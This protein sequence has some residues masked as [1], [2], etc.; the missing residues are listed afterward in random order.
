MSLSILLQKLLHA[1]KTKIK[2]LFQEIL[3]KLKRFMILGFFQDIT[4]SNPNWQLI[5]ILT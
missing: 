4:S 1:L 5:N 3:K 2:K